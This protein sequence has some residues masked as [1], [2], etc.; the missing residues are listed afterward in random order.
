[1][2][3]QEVTLEDGS[4]GRGMI[5][6][7][8]ENLSIIVRMTVLPFEGVG[9]VTKSRAMCDQGRV[10]TGRGQSSPDAGL[11][12]VLFLAQTEQVALSIVVHQKRLWRKARVRF[13]PG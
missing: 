12:E 3:H 10:G 9:P 5:L 7:D 11:V 2:A 4:L 13:T 8:L 1:M 6:T